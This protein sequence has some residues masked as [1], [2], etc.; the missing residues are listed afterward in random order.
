MRFSPGGAAVEGFRLIGAKPGTYLGWVLFYLVSIIVLGA[1]VILAMLPLFMSIAKVGGGFPATDPTAMGAFFRANLPALVIAGLVAVPLILL[2][3]AVFTGAIYRAVLRPE[4]KGFAYI[5]LGADEFRLFA[6]N[7]LI[8]VVLI[9]VMLTVGVVAALLMGALA[10]MKLYWAMVLLGI[11]LFCLYIWVVVRLVLCAP[12]TFAE[13]RV[14]LFG[15]WKLTRNH[16]WGLIGMFL[17]LVAIAIG[18]AFVNFVVQML[19]TGANAFAVHPASHSGAGLVGSLVYVVFSL[20]FGTFQTVVLT[21]PAAAAY[22][23][24][25]PRKDHSHVFA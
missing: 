23:D 9:G 8:F 1:G 22:R 2:W 25:S 18:L 12:Q 6:L 4:D 17:V 21:V 3:T 13:K 7:L 14:T 24:L 20:F 16:V 15:S 11:V 19:L 10:A 5:R